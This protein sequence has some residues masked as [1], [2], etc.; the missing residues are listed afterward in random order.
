MRFAFIW[1]A[2]QTTYIG[3]FITMIVFL[4]KLKTQVTQVQARL[5]SLTA[6]VRAEVTK[7]I[8]S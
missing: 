1:I 4:L 5:A 8:A 2:L 7:E 6:V 3:L